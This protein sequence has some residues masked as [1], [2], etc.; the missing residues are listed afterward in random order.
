MVLRI[1]F[2]TSNPVTNTANARFAF[3]HSFQADPAYL[4]GP[5]ILQ[6]HSHDDPVGLLT[7]PALITYHLPLNK[8]VPV[9]LPPPDGVDA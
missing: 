8:D 3:I 4:C 7:S 5:K 1:R 9:L 2:F 6:A